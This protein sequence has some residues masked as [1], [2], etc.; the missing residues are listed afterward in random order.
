MRAPTGYGVVLAAMLVLSLPRPGVADDGL[1]APLAS[2][3]E[4]EA[5]IHALGEPLDHDRLSHIFFTL[6]QL[7]DD[8]ERERLQ[9]LLHT[10][11][12][13]L[14]PVSAT[15]QG[16]AVEPTADFQVRSGGEDNA[17]TV[18]ELQVRIDALML[19]PEAAVEDLRARD[20]VVSAIAGLSDPVQRE[21]LL[22][23]LEAREAQF[24]LGPPGPVAE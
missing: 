2:A 10:R 14:A 7:E 3:S 21:A 9:Q 19:G 16:P 1:G 6:G 24:S 23:H 22:R 5:A 18:E 13:T 20:A 12:Q 15:A 4:L 17:V 11:L 8:A